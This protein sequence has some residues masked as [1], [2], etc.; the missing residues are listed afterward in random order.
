MVASQAAEMI[1]WMAKNVP[2]GKNILVNAAQGNYLAFLDGGRHEWSRLRLD[3]ERCVPRPNTQIR[4]NPD[5]T[6]FPE[7]RPTR[8]GF[9]RWAGVKSSPCPCLTS[10]DRYGAETPTT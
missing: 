1:D 6:P 4:C 2:E 3:Q 10:W 7:Y 5:R 8:S 9:R